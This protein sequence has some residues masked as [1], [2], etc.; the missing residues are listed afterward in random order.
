MEPPNIVTHYT[1]L[2]AQD[3]L[4]ADRQTQAPFDSWTAGA[5]SVARALTESTLETEPL[6][7]RIRELARPG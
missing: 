3:R 4:Y 7:E 1:V 6:R 2:P 5:E